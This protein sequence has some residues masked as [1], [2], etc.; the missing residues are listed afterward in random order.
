MKPLSG[1][2]RR[3]LASALLVFG[4]ATR[5]VANEPLVTV[6]LDTENPGPVI[7]ADFEGLSFEASLLLPGPDGVHYFRR[8]NHALIHL[9]HTLGIKSLR[10]GGNTAD[11]DARK[12]PDEADLDSLFAF[13]KAA[14]VKIIYCL[15]LHGGDPQADARTAKYTAFYSTRN[16]YVARPLANGIKAFDLSGHGRV[17]PVELSSESSRLAAYAVLSEVAVVRQRLAKLAPEAGLEPATHRLTADC[18]TI[19]LLWNPNGR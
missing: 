13:A 14:E 12:L 1:L 4:L 7:P 18:S 6:T 10:L 17:V 2:N 3:R 15:R 8:D 9:F 11:R 16:G 19:E 5:T